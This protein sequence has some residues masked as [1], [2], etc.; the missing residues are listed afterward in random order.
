MDGRLGSMLAFQDDFK[1]LSPI[2]KIQSP[3]IVSTG[4]RLNCSTKSRETCCRT[5]LNLSG[6][7]NL[8][9]KTAQLC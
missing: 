6:L 7:L 3:L 9:K 5:K 1:P 4:N 8:Q 2:N